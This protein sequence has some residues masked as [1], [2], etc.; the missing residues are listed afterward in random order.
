MPARRKRKKVH[1]FARVEKRR[2]RRET[3]NIKAGALS[4]EEKDEDEETA[5]YC[6]VVASAHLGRKRWDGCSAA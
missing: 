5:F 2:G 3:E 4:K 6:V 1:A